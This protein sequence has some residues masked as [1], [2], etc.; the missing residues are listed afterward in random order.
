MFYVWAVV[1]A[2]GLP[3][4]DAVE[5]DADAA[6]AKFLQSRPPGQESPLDW[7]AWQALGYAC[8]RFRLSRENGRER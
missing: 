7:G 2:E 1:N 8:E 6:I 4:I 3:V 5:A